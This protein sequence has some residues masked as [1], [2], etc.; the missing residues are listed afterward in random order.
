MDR[1]KKLGG[2]RRRGRG[3]EKGRGIN[4]IG[5]QEDNAKDWKKRK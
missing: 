1:K 5:T 3:R 4:E 2:E